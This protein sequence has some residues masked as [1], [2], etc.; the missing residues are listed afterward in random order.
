MKKKTTRSLVITNIIFLIPL[1]IYGVFKNGYLLYDRNLIPFYLI[2]KP[3]YLTIVSIVIKFAFDLIINHRLSINYNLLY[4]VL[5]SMIMPYN[6]NFI[7]YTI[8]LIITYFLTTLL[9][10]KIKFN[11]VCL[12]ALIIILVNSIFYKFT[13]LSPL[14]AKF[15]FAFSFFDLLMGRSI[16]SISSTSIFFSLLAYTLLINSYYYKKDMP[17]AINLTFLGLAFITYLF[18]HDLSFLLNSE[19]IFAS[20][21]IATLP[22]YSPYKVKDQ[23]ISGILIGL[24][25]FIIALFF[26]D[27]ISIYLA[28]FLV[29]LLGN[30]KKDGKKKQKI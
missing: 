2:F 19:I 5:V 30:L 26:N 12:M 25:T 11:K 10:S 18:N 7:I 20:I 1:I 22:K 27:T 24:I 8:T 6:I 9:E 13:Y 16:G 4:M 29:S 28:I 23:V 21:F 17:L 15:N 3:I 14:E